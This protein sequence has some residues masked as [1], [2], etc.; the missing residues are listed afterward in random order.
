ME[1]QTLMSGDTRGKRVAGAYMIVAAGLWVLAFFVAEALSTTLLSVLAGAPLGYFLLRG[2]SW[3]AKPSLVV[4]GV[5]LVLAAIQCPDGSRQWLLV[6][7][8]MVASLTV[9]LLGDA[10]KA[11]IVAG[12]VLFA[13]Y[14]LGMASMIVLYRADW[15]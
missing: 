9:L 3:A 14:V 1:V 13:L 12:T 2:R 15:D 6:P 11:R 10:D 7:G 4:L 8:L 5:G